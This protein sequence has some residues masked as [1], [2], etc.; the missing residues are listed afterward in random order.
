MS[1][2]LSLCIEHFYEHIILRANWFYYKNAELQMR[3]K[4][5]S[6]KKNKMLLFFFLNAKTK[7]SSSTQP[8]PLPSELSDDTSY[9]LCLQEINVLHFFPP[10]A[11]SQFHCNN[12]S[13]FLSP[14]AAHY[15]QI[16][17]MELVLT[18]PVTRMENIICQN[19]YFSLTYV[20][21]ALEGCP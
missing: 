7:S 12:S 11:P 1:E 18:N 4:K 16:C 10:T 15:Q 14:Y 17:L 6:N 13:V 21:N 20:C 9:S 3:K 5:T 2:N 19:Y 8:V